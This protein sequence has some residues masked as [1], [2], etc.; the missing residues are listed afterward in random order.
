[1]FR[2][3]MII[4]HHELSDWLGE[5]RHRYNNFNQA[6]SAFMP[7][8][9]GDVLQDPRSKGVEH[10]IN[11][12]FTTQPMVLVGIARKF[13]HPS[14]TI[15][16]LYVFPDHRRKGYASYLVNEVQ[17]MTTKNNYVHA[18]VEHS[19]LNQL[20]PFYKRLGFKEVKGYSVDPTG[21]RLYDFLWSK[22]E[23]QILR[24]P[25]GLAIKPIS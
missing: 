4:Q 9:R 12:D 14:V 18:S 25:D 1:M 16:G 13:N 11:M 23:I 19:K 17:K 2:E 7:K 20:R 15:T 3:M 10:I 21:T 6:Y 8:F 22:R 5:D 24:T